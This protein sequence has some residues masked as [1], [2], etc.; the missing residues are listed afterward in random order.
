[1]DSKGL[2]K[3]EEKVRKPAQKVSPNCSSQALIS[4]VLYLANGI[5][6]PLAQIFLVVVGSQ[7]TIVLRSVGL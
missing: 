2:S 6:H 5:E 3:D 1:M 7:T 4:T